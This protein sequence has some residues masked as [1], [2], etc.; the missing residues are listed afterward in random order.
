MVDKYQWMM[1]SSE[2]ISIKDNA[3]GEVSMESKN[4]DMQSIFNELSEKNKDLMM[5]LAKSVKYAQQAAEK[6]CNSSDSRPA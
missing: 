6:P 3:K 4:T 2:I 5:L 1:Y